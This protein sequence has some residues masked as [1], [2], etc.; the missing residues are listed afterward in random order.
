MVKIAWRDAK[1]LVMDPKVKKA[2]EENGI[3]YK[4]F[5]C[6]PSFADTYTFCE[7]YGFSL[8]QSANTIIVASKGDDTKYAACV[9]LATTKLDVNKKVCE[10]LGVKRASFAPY[11]ATPEI[12]G[13]MVGGVTIFGLK[14]PICVDSKVMDEKEI[15]MGGGNRSIKALLNP[16]ELKKIP[17]LQ[18]VEGLAIPK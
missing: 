5:E 3:E 13:M 6:D 17:G 2:L 18:V 7:K 11:E 10:L 15:V 1:I 12:T 16:Q 9:A 8:S 4:I 14:M